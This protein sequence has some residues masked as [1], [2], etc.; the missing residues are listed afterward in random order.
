MKDIK[1]QSTQ[2]VN[3]FGHNPN[4]SGSKSTPVKCCKEKIN[5]LEAH[6]IAQLKLQN[7][8]FHYYKKVQKMATRRK[9]KVFS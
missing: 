6:K 4:L 9:L 1:V 2:L 3:F 5:K 7:L 8:D